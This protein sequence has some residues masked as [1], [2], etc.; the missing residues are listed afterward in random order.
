MRTAILALSLSVL[1]AFPA[2]AGKPLP[3]GS[4]VLAELGG[5]P[6]AARNAPTLVSDGNGGI[7]GN[8]GCN[9]YGGMAVTGEGTLAFENL[10]S[11]LMACDASALEGEF[12]DALAATRGYRLDDTGLVLTGAAGEILAE[13]VPGD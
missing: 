11:T 10:M 1:A 2:H 13:L 3:P 4:W 8:G 9:S 6:V 12:F 7:N 5:E